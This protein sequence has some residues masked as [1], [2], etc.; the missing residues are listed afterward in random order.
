MLETTKATAPMEL[1]EAVSF[2][3]ILAWDDLFKR[4]QPRFVRVEYVREPEQ[5]L[6]HLSVW[7]VKTGGY[8][9]LVCNYWM[10]PS[11]VHP[12]GARFG[13]GF[14]SD[15]LVQAFEFIMHTQGQFMRSADAYGQHLVLVY[16]PDG[17][18]R[19][20]AAP[21]R[22]AQAL[23][24]GAASREAS[25]PA[26]ALRQDE[27]AYARMDGEGYPA[28]RTSSMPDAT[29]YSGEEPMSAAVSPSR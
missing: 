27:E 16:P 9:D 22:G 7:S 14:D 5:P 26:E 25:K 10:S 15:Q 1:N 28:L 21:W 2:A 11:L 13:N 6:D 12:S 20:A 3:L 19:T 29:G 18:D 4:A 8:Q 17:Q 24:S 23:K